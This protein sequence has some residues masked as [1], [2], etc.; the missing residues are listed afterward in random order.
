MYEGRFGSGD[1]EYGVSVCVVVV[2]WQPEGLL[3]GG[4]RRV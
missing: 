2:C 3:E 1:G 4:F